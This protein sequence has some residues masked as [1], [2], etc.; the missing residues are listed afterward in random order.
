MKA[1]KKHLLRVNWLLVGILTISFGLRT[2]HL[3]WDQGQHLHPDERF[4]VMVSSAM[5]VSPSLNAYLDPLKSTMNPLNIGH[6]FFVYG[7]FP[8]IVTK[9]VAIALEKDFYG[10][11]H[12][13]GRALSALVD[14]SIVLCIYLAMRKI[15][16]VVLDSSIQIAPSIAYWA[17]FLYGISVLPIQQSHFFTTDT[18]ANAA[19]VWGMTIL[20]HAWNHTHDGTHKNSQIR[21]VILKKTLSIILAGICV[22]MAIASK[23][24]AV[25][26]LP[27]FG[28]LLFVLVGTLELQSK[29]HSVFLQRCLL[30][31][32]FGATLMVTIYLAVRIAGPYYFAT[33][34]IFSLRLHPNFIDNIEELKRLSNSD[35]WFPPGVQWIHKS[36]PWFA[37]Q[38]IAWFGLGLG[39]TIATVVGFAVL[40]GGWL[41]YQVKKSGI[42]LSI[43]LWGVVVWATGILLYQAM[44]IA[45]TLRYFL[46]LYPFFAVL[47]AIG[48][49]WLFCR[50]EATPYRLSVKRAMQAVLVVVVS[51]W[52]VA[53]CHIYTVP[54]SRIAASKWMWDNMPNGS[55][56]GLEHWDDPLPLNLPGTGGKVITGV[57]M[58]IFG[59]DTDE[60]WV[61]M[62]QKFAQ[63]QYYVM[64]S[65]RGWGSVTTV[66]ERFPQQT[67]FYKDLFA[68]KTEFTH[69]K[70]FTSYPTLC[71]PWTQICYH[72]D[73]QW[74]EEAFTVYD[75]P[76]VMIYIKK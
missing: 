33:S 18:F 31:V 57:E 37:L 20:I 4:L 60:K 19:G 47:A 34:N 70:T 10:G 12:L 69:L 36:K 71:V 73:D 28:C 39:M 14:T 67:K 50:I 2:M 24:S 29:R 32:I 38:N 68:E 5:R 62:K 59:Q 49:H 7:T 46:I 74:S 53:F 56:I 54:H 65:N 61:Q 41:K 21:S 42:T 9:F 23:I 40:L 58:P 63:I 17:A 51:L 16:K 35:G 43:A 22:G 66:P 25:Y 15:R 6:K 11:L 13:V 1:L 26:I 75:H 30:F 27:V 3:D 52:T 76:K 48:I 55:Q 72:F 64:T 8:L 45:H 44:Q